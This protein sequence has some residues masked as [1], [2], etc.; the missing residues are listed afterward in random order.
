MVTGPR[1][2]ALLATSEPDEA[3]PCFAAEYVQ[4]LTLSGGIQER[5]PLATAMTAAL[6]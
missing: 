2:A 1:I 3:P 4:G 6:G 5:G